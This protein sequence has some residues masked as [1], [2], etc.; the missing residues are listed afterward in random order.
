MPIDT[1]VRAHQSV[2]SDAS[3]TGNA[4][5]TCAI[6]EPTVMDYSQQSGAAHDRPIDYDEN[7][8]SSF[9]TVA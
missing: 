6:F 4:T 1:W 9:E 3:T 8:D 5:G 2:E 7:S